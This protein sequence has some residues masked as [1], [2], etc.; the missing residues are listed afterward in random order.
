M[1]HATYADLIRPRSRAAA[2]TYNV[3]LVL[4]GS[5]LIAL[6]ARVTVTLPFTVIPVTGQ[7]FA[8]LLVG[9]LLGSRRG[10]ASV[11][12]YLLEGAIGLPVFARGAAGLLYMFG[13]TCGYMVGF[14]AAA[15]VTG[16]LAENGWDRSY[17]RTVA[18]MSL[19]TAALF[20]PGVIWLSVLPGG[21]GPAGAV[22]VGLLP[23]LPGAAVKIA[24][25]AALLPTGWK[26][27]RR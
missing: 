3:G 6:S 18:A 21:P 9:A 1:T 23:F 17:L 8:V 10:V 14:L 11:A 19:G 26:L 13:P 15:W 27:L 5:V 20:V 25:A 22:V 12:A 4:A 24:L 7:T 16:R 2:W